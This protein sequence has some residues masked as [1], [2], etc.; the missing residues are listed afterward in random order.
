[1]KLVS[2]PVSARATGTGVIARWHDHRPLSRALRSG[3]PL[4]RS[5]A[6]IDSIVAALQHG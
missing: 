5:E 1:L 4:V 2:A 3:T 6:R